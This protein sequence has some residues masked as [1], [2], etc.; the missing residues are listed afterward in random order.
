MPF[1]MPTELLATLP[2]SSAC[3]HADQPSQHCSLFPSTLLAAGA[4]LAWARREAATLLRS[5]LAA[6]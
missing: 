1:Q 5:G 2:L 4:E 3:R 6:Y